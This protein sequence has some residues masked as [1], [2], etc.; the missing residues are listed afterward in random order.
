[1]LRFRVAERLSGWAAEH[2]RGHLHSFMNNLYINSTYL[3]V[4]LRVAGAVPRILFHPKKE[5]LRA[6]IINRLNEEGSNADEPLNI[7]LSDYSR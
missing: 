1:M 5:R 4:C 6:K 3:F 2:A 7:S